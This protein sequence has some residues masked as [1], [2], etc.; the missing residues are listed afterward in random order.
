M[1]RPPSSARPRPRVDAKDGARLGADIF[2]EQGS[3]VEPLAVSGR[4]AARLFDCS[5]RHWAGL[6]ARGLVPR[7]LRLGANRKV[8]SVETLRRWA[9]YGA[10]NREHFE[11][12]ERA[13]EGR[14]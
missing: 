14:P 12:L 3:G 6:D 9:A 8:W 1:S 4:K 11:Q 10:P 7:A 13:R 5:P 2:G